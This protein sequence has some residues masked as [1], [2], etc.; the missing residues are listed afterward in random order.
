MHEAVQLYKALDL[1]LLWKHRENGTDIPYIQSSRLRF[2][3]C[4]AQKAQNDGQERS[5][6]QATGLGRCWAGHRLDD[7]P[8]GS[9][10]V[11]FPSL[12]FF[13]QI[14]ILSSIPLPRLGAPIDYALLTSFR[15]AAS[16]RLN[17]F[18]EV[19]QRR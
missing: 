5:E 17:G 11:A 8:H 13:L 9:D 1:H 2:E 19:S 3:S 15:F 14:N 12:R 4:P 18:S 10:A 6:G 7:A 16:L